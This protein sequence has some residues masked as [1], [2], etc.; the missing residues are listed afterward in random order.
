[1]RSKLFR[2]LEKNIYPFGTRGLL[3]YSE[4]V[5]D[6][7]HKKDKRIYK[8]TEVMFTVGLKD[9]PDTILEAGLHKIWRAELEEIAGSECDGCN[10]RFEADSSVRNVSPDKIEVARGASPEELV[11]KKSFTLTVNI[12]LRIPIEEV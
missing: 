8:I 3:N 7:F 5:V 2:W 12:F 4:Q 6:R 1:M 9:A 10:L 11:P